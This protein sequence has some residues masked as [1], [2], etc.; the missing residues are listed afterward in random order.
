MLKGLGKKLLQISEN[1]AQK[2][3][4]MRQMAQE[5]P[6]SLRMKT[7]FIMKN[8]NKSFDEYF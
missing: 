8:Q 2:F 6:T 1:K 5:S 7:S 4:R 3:A